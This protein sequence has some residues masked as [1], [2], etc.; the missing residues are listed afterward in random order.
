MSGINNAKKLIMD[1]E[2]KFNRWNERSCFKLK[3]VGNLSVADMEEL[4][5]Y[6]KAYIQSGGQGF[7]GLVKPRG[8]IKEVLVKYGLYS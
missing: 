7:P 4:K 6:A 1:I 5:L 2:K 3:G 8:S